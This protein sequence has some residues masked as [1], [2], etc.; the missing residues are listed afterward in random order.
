MNPGSAIPKQ[1]LALARCVF[2]AEIG[3]GR[4]VVTQLV[5]LG[6]ERPGNPGATERRESLD[7]SSTLDR[8]DSGNQRDFDAVPADH[9]LA[10]LKKV[11]VIKKQLGDDK[12]RAGIDFLF[13]MLPVHDLPLFARNMAF[14]EAGNPDAEVA[15]LPD[16]A[17]QLVREFE[18]SRSRLKFRPI[19]RIAPQR[20]DVFYA[21]RF[22]LRQQVANLLAGCAYASKMSHRCKPMLL[23]NPLHDHQRLITRA[24]ARAIGHRTVIG[25]GLQQCRNGFLEQVPVAFLRFGRKKFERDNRA[26]RGALLGVNVADKLH[27]YSAWSKPEP[28]PSPHAAGPFPKVI[29]YQTVLRHP[30]T[31]KRSV[32]FASPPL[33]QMAETEPTSDGLLSSVRRLVRIL[34]ATLQNRAEL[35]A[36][37]L[38]EERYRIVEILLLAGAAMVLALLSLMLFSGVIVFAFPAEYRLYIAAGLGVVYLVSGATLGMRIKRLLRE[39]PFT[40]TVQQLKKDVECVTPPK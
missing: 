14:R 8:D 24:P 38:Q 39:Q 36:L 15:L 34:G 37:E 9:M 21:Q 26:P 40:E 28:I 10:E 12:I 23:L 16:E 27:V 31:C 22:D 11:G 4:I 32:G 1:L 30:N 33:T 25:V 7:L 35:L 20:Q 19:G 17:D 5:Q 13:Q 29:A 3:H 6:G 18:P 2:D